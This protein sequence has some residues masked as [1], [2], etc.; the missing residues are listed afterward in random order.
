LSGPA[1]KVF[2]TAGSKVQ[3]K[4]LLEAYQLFPNKDE[5]FLTPTS[6][7]PEDF[8]FNKLAGNSTL[9]QQV[10]D[11]KTEEEIRK[12][13]EPGLAKF[14]AVRKKYLIYKDFE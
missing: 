9:M 1:D 8:F 10:K 7:K 11:G 12:S 6:N 3:V 4:W 13:W 14:K 5:F 2:I